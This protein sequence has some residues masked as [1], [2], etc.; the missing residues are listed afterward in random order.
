MSF[1]GTECSK[2]L[3]SGC[4]S[5][6]LLPGVPRVSPSLSGD[7]MDKIYVQSGFRCIGK[8]GPRDVGQTCNRGGSSLQGPSRIL[9]DIL[10]GSQKRWGGE[11]NLEL[12]ATQCV[13]GQETFQDGHTQGGHFG[14]PARGLVNLNGPER[15]LFSCPYQA[16][17]EEVSEVRLPGEGVSVQSTSVR[18]NS[19]SE[20]VHSSSG[21]GYGL[22]QKGGG[23]HIPLPGRPIIKKQSEGS[24]LQ[25]RRLYP[26]NISRH[27]VSFKP[28]K[29]SPRTYSRPGLYRSKVQDRSRKGLPSCRKNGKPHTLCEVIPCG[30]LQVCQ[31]VHATAGPDGLFTGSSSLGEVVHET[32]SNVPHVLLVSPESRFRIQDSGEKNLASSPSLVGRQGESFTRKVPKPSKGSV[33]GDHRCIIGWLGGSRGRSAC[34]RSVVSIRQK[35]SHKSSRAES[36]FPLYEVIPS[37]F[38]RKDCVGKNRQHH[39]VVLHQQT[40]RNKGSST[41][42]SDFSDAGVVQGAQNSAFGSAHS[43]G[44]ECL[45][46]Q[47]VKEDSDSLL[48]V[49]PSSE[50]GRPDFSGPGE[51]PSGSFCIQGESET[52]LL[53]VQSLRDGSFCDRCSK[54]KL[55]GHVGL[56]LPTFSPS[57][58]GYQQDKGAKGNSHS[59]CP[60]VSLEVLVPG[61]PPSSGGFSVQASPEV[62]LI[63]PTQGEVCSPPAPGIQPGGL[64][65]KRGT[66]IEGGVSQAAAETILSA[67]ASSTYRGYECGWRSFCLWCEQNGF[68]PR[69]TTIAQIVNH[70]QGVLQTSKKAN[71]MKHRLASINAFHPGFKPYNSLW[72]VPII[73]EFKQGAFKKF[74]VIKNPVPTWDLPFVLDALM[75][76]PYEPMEESSLENLTLK[77][78]FLVAVTSGR[79]VSEIHA[80]DCREEWLVISNQRAILRTNPLFRPKIASD[81]NINAKIVLKAFFPNP[82]NAHQTEL[83]SLDVVRS[84]NHY[85]EKT[86][87][88]RTSSQLF[89]S[90]QEGKKGVPITKDTIARWIKQCILRAYSSKDKATPVGV[91]AHSTRAM[92]TSWA[93]VF[94]A[95]AQ[96]I[97]EAATW[98][99]DSTFCKFYRL[100]VLSLPEHNFGEAVIKAATSRRSS[101]FK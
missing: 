56:C 3:D 80:V 68:N 29:V 44:T 76:H 8:G 39:G 58:S 14:R 16:F 13:D 40:G 87:P 26:K 12:E 34:A 32:I 77:T 10:S 43:R 25:A 69:E 61:T 100:D 62:K 51:T 41:M 33:H 88:F 67:K 83:H 98:S 82:R 71:T 30:E 9:L 21:R 49:V 70:L 52:S 54:P 92:S 90:Y 81:K 37:P 53:R 63:D 79:R 73:K 84:L 19:Y 48:R 96:S 89:L 72:V 45:S 65:I 27:R 15:C 74:P 4:G 95:S 38:G 20:V 66:I 78:A 86:K 1:L 23:V 46:R 64:E 28:Q 35:P 22:N 75:R 5:T 94:G 24:S 59:D 47:S 7:K 18:S 57:T 55:D 6:G 60:N 97:C 36:R 85:L 17:P 101:R 11:T 91:K 99:S 31:T 2:H 93:E 42:H 50:G